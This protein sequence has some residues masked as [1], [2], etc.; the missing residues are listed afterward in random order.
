MKTA[1]V[2]ALLSFLILFTSMQGHAEIEKTGV[3]SEQGLRLFWWP[4]LAPV[5]GWHQESEASYEN[6]IN[7]NAPDGYT[8]AD[9]EVVIYAKALYKPRI[10]NTK[11]LDMLIQEDKTEFLARDPEIIIAEVE[12]LKTGDGQLLKSLTFFPKKKGNWEQVSYGEEGDFYLIF[13]VSSRTKEGFGRA[14]SAY[15]QFIAKYKEKY[16]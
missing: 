8:F 9:A 4:K 15:K 14:L 13:T 6:G 16:K 11:S 7:A 5:E 3:P 10:P 12:S 2:S 1:F